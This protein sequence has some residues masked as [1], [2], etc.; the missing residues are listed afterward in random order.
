MY[1]YNNTVPIVRR[2]PFFIGPDYFYPQR[3]HLETSRDHFLLTYNTFHWLRPLFQWPIL[4]FLSLKSLFT[5]RNIFFC[6]RL[7]IFAGWNHFITS[8]YHFF[9]GRDYLF[10]SRYHFVDGL[11]NFLS[12][13]LLILW[14]ADI[15]F[16]YWLKSFFTGW[17]HFFGYVLHFSLSEIMFSLA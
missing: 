8:W 4:L 14:M 7:H 15:F 13:K 10:N 12:V 11:D 5:G 2:D 6:D 16:V 17:D 9:K 3:N 1:T